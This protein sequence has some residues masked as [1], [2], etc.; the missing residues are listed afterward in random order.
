[1][2]NCDQCE[3]EAALIECPECGDRC[4]DNCIAGVGVRCFQC[5]EAEGDE[6][7]Q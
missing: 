7:E 1:M 4:C 2:M 3:R 6:Q 5:E